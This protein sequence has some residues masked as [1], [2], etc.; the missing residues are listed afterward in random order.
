MAKRGGGGLKVIGGTKDAGSSH[1]LKKDMAKAKGSE[2]A[3]K[4]K[5]K[6]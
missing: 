5:K 3:M 6:K 4:G 2:K 1:L